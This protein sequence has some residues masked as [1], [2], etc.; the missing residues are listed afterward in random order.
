MINLDCVKCNYK[1]Q[2][3]NIYVQI[4]KVNRNT[5]KIRIFYRHSILKQI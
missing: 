4:C 2:I 3:F 1:I 5:N